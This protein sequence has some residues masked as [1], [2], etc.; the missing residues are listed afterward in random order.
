MDKLPSVKCR[1]CGGEVQL[2]RRK[3]KDVPV[4]FEVIARCHG[5]VHVAFVGKRGLRAADDMLAFLRIA[6]S[7]AATMEEARR[8]YGPMPAEPGAVAVLFE[9]R[10]PSDG[11]FIVD[12]LDEESCW[13][14]QKH[15]DDLA[16]AEAYRAELEGKVDA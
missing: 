16:S 10:S 14:T 6:T 9:V 11:V 2:T 4:H 12:S 8:V 1:T 3:P 7:M 15:F 13:V 5:M